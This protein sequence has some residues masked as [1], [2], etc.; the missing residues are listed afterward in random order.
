MK[1]P[2]H[3]LKLTAPAVNPLAVYF[4]GRQVAVPSA[5]SLTWALG[6]RS[7]RGNLDDDNRNAL[8]L[9]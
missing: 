6:G 9:T 4:F 2:D 5:R 1:G 8:R 7:L 3:S